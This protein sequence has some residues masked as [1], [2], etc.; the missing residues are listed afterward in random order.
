MSHAG[1][2]IGIPGFDGLKVNSI[3]YAC[4]PRHP[5][6]LPMPYP[7]P[8]QNLP[9]GGQTGAEV[10]DSDAGRGQLERNRGTAFT[11]LS[12]A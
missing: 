8:A 1:M 6:V 3:S 4:T 12:V 2:I 7:S 5:A 10:T 11:F 9:R